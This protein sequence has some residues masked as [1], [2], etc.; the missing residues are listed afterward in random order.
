MKARRSVVWL[1]AAAVLLVALIIWFGKQEPVDKAL[2]TAP[3]ANP[4][5]LPSGSALAEPS[6]HA[7][8]SPA[9]ASSPPANARI[10][11]N[12][13]TRLG[14]SKAERML[15]VLSNYNDMPIVFY[16]KIEDQFSNP[17]PSA[18][19]EFSIQYNNGMDVGVKRGQTASDARGFFTVT[20]HTGERLSTSPKKLGYALASTGGGGV[21]SQLWPEA[22]R[23]HPDPSNPVLIKMWK[24][25]GAEPLLSISQRYKLHYTQAPIYV[26]LVVGKIVPQGGDVKIIVNRPPGVISGRNPQDWGLDIEAVNGGLMDSGGQEAV[27]YA[28]PDAGYQPSETFTM[29]TRSNTW[30]MAVH[31]GFFFTSRNRQ[32]YGKLGLSFHINDAPDGFMDMAF[33]G[34]ANTNASRNLECDPNTLKPR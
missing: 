8:A 9:Q 12:Y 31:Q 1:T 6:Q 34:V 7:V 16:G 22:E 10:D 13:G 20:G 18:I 4:A 21:Y 19:V 2:P 27:T 25:Q 3:E 29:S 14:E 30:Y 23:A 11:P 24:L 5:P 33:S 17:V 28:A 15:N 26:D 32:V